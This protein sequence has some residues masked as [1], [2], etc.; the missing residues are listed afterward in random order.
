MCRARFLAYFLVAPENEEPTD[1]SEEP[2]EEESRSSWQ[3]FYDALNN[4]VAVEP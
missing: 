3:R 4:L 2:H 1:E